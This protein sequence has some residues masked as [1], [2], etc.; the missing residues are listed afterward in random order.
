MSVVRRPAV[1]AAVVIALVIAGCKGKEEPQAAA[2]A[3][4]SV[5][6][7][8]HD[9]ASGMM[10]DLP[11]SWRGRYRVGVGITAPAEGL[12]RELAF[13]YVRADSSSEAEAPMLIARLFDRSAWQAIA[14]DTL[15]AAFG[16]A[17]GGDST[18]AIVLRR[19]ASNPYQ[20]GTVDA[21]AYDSLMIALMQRPLRAAFRPGNR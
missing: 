8:F 6:H 18:H 15:R 2:G 11:S 13:R 12:Q 1:L 21:A 7:F 20:A 17:S 10:L 3:R 5:G 4:P 9:T 19:A 16:A 14:N